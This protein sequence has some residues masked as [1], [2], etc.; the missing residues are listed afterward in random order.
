[1]LIIRGKQDIYISRGDTKRIGV[2]LCVKANS[3][4]DDYEIVEGEYIVFKLWDKE[5]KN[6]I[7]TLQSEPSTTIIEIP[8]EFTERLQEKEF[9]YSVD[10]QMFDG[11]K[12]TVIGETP[13]TRPKFIILEA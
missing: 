9:R 12:D 3:I 7:S 13:N 4:T 5:F 1:M 10:L 11:T 8:A 6:V 2:N